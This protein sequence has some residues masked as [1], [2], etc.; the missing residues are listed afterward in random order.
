MSTKRLF[1]DGWQF[2]KTDL[3][4]TTIENLVFK[5]VEVPHDWLIWDSTN[6][7]EDSIGWYKKTFHYDGKS[8]HISLRFDGVYMDSTLYVNEKKVGEWKYGY[9]TFEHEITE[10]LKTGENEI[11]LKVNYQAPNSRWYSGAGIYRNVWLI[12]RDEEYIPE[13][14]I[15]VAIEEQEGNRWTVDIETEIVA[16]KVVSIVHRIHDGDYLVAENKS[17]RSKETERRELLF[18]Q[19]P[20]LWNLELPHLYILTTDLLNH[21]GEVIQQVEQKIGFRTIEMSPNNGLT[22]NDKKIKINGTCEHHDLGSMGAAF[23]SEAARYR[24]SLLKKMGVNG[25]R[26]A[27]NMPARELMELTDEMGFLVVSE[28]FDMWERTKTTYDY[29]RFF[30]K[31]AYKDVKSWVRRDRNHPSLL[32]WSIGNEIYDTH[33]D[34]RGQDIT[35][36][37][38][39]YVEEFDPKGNAPVTIGSNYMP[40]E[41]ARKCADIVKYA[42]YNYGEK[43]YND[44]HEAHPDWIIYGAET[45]SVVQS[46]GIYH[47]PYQQSILA[48]DDEQCSALGNSSTSWGAKSTEHVIRWERDT[49]FSLGQFIWTGFD[50]IGEP[51]PYHTKNAY[52][53]QLDTA[54]FPKDSYF[55]YQSAWTDVEESPMIH[56]FPYWDFNP[57]QTVD[58]RVAT[59]APKV[60]LQLNDRTIGEREIDHENGE[61]IVPTWQVPYEH[62]KIRAIAYDYEGN[63]LAE[64][65][66]YSFGDAKKLALKTNRQEIEANGQDLLFVEIFAEDA[67][68]YTVENATNRVDV[69]VKG[70]GRLVGLDNGDSTD[71]DQYKGTSKRLFSGKLMAIVQATDETGE[72]ELIAQSIG[73]DAVERTF[74]AVVSIDRSVLNG[75]STSYQACEPREIVTGQAN[76]IPVRKLE[77]TSQNG[78]QFSEKLTEMQVEVRLYPE[79]TTYKEVEW[80]VVND[81]GIESTIAEIV[82]K[83]HK[84]IVRAKGDGNFR[85]RCTSKNG[86]DKVKLISELDMQAEGLGTAYKNPY[87]LISGGLYDDFEGEVSNGNERGIATSRDGKTTVGYH[88]I[89][90]GRLGSNQITLPVFAL[91]DEEY[92]IQIWKGKPHSQGSELLAEVIYQKPSQ[93]NTY[94]EETYLLS[95]KVKG[96]T[97]IYFVVQAKIHLKGFLFEEFNRAFEKNKAVDADH[98]YGDTF[99]KRENTVEGIGNNVSLIFEDMDFFSKAA[100][101]LIIKGHSPI[102]K[103]TIHVRFEDQEGQEHNQM[104]EFLESE[105]YEEQYFSL[106]KITGKGKISF[107]F[108]PGSHFNFESFIFE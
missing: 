57:G 24:L 17:S 43:Y 30:K 54:N 108:L 20:K 91:S 9:S 21:K 38:K 47:F 98:I 88:G 81:S 60:E 26:T 34:E 28:A 55:M 82:S 93:W 36:H 77:M 4:K 10:A 11:L 99:E 94:Q 51:T 104:I 89:D 75:N 19:S 70:A 49:A 56:L 42:G 62:G 86:T 1:N 67:D 92:P 83:N 95:N 68:G 100:T 101:R 45:A 35:R 59:N 103:N 12:E 40:W 8:N 71:Y 37:L 25:I 78:R 90:F 48:D 85:I 29:G 102:D 96:I 61:E 5:E 53:G 76:E 105:N 2:A 33:A 15:Y 3:G 7:Y 79:N 44:Q 80:S 106:E 23:N 73:L 13:D 97:S 66:R 69:Q 65:T 22:L 87:E 14:G 16:K 58:V 74:Q 32:M 31:W 84:A 63:I 50:Y 27:H 72:I 46:R 52:F 41:N 6:L 39:A 18:V 64:Q 107:V